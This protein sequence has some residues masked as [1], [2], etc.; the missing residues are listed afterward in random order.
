MKK[1]ESR[2][3]D[4]ADT[5]RVSDQEEYP[6][7]QVR[8]HGVH[9]S[10]L[11]TGRRRLLLGAGLFTVGFFVLSM[12]LV[13]V[14][15]FNEVRTPVA[16]NE[17]AEFN[18]GPARADIVDRNGVVLATNLITHSLYADPQDVRDSSDAANRLIDVL[19]GID[20]EEVSA[21][22]ASDRQFVWL[23]RHL[24][25]RQVAAVNALGEPGFRFIEEQRRLYP[26]GSLLVHAVGYAKIDNRGLSGLESTYDERLLAQPNR[27][28]TL[29][30]DLRFQHAM[31][32]ELTR[33]VAMH[34]PLGAVGIVMD[35]AT[36]GL[37]ALVSLPDFNP[38]DNGKVE[39]SALFNRATLGVY[40][41]GSTFKIF[42]AAMGIDSG[43]FTLQDSFDASEPLRFGRNN[44]IRDFHGEARRLSVPEIFIHSSNIG[45]AKMAL[46]VGGSAQREFLARLGLLD[47]AGIELP[48]I[49]MPHYPSDWKDVNTATIGFGHGIAVSPVHLAAAI[50]ALVNGGLWHSPTLLAENEK[51]G[52]AVRVVSEATSHT[53][54]Q[55][56]RLAVTHGTG[57]NAEVGGYWVGGKTGTAEKVGP[58]GY[59]RR[60]VL[61]SFVG[62][63]PITRP[64]YLVL[65]MLD[66][67]KG[68][69]STHGYATGGWIA[70]P[71]VARVIA[72]V[73]PMVGITTIVEAP[74]DNDFPTTVIKLDGN[75]LRLAAY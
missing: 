6:S 11:E 64:R 54:R 45:A 38:N 67:P 42:T 27:Q 10:S 52:K 25:P 19:H 56:L 59:D 26:H 12:R 17:A 24:K 47:R 65:A 39:S 62:V 34:R 63:F 51:P 48:E 70:A 18:D 30:I 1:L 8:I 43:V 68:T 4:P 72:K 57:R 44:I 73:G 7:A 28:L 15:L 21:R 50:A 71:V 41:M 22:L 66:E 16:V 29:S 40:E 55:L 36:G 32:E 2:W 37:R 69:P 14:A 31:Y 46:A 58:N 60:R 9:K 61:S 49:G 5:Q 3:G 23:K 20:L 75:E 35:V 13:E 74:I 33:A 53:I